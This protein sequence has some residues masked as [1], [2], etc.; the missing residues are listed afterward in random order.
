MSTSSNAGGPDRRE[1]RNL[2]GG[3]MYR[4]DGAGVVA[5]LGPFRRFRD[6]LSRWPDELTRWYGYSDERQRGRARFWL[7]EQGYQPTARASI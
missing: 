3:A 7:V 4:V 1:W 5:P 6:V 2:L